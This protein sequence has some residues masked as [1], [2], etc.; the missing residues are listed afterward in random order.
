VTSKKKSQIGAANAEV[1]RCQLTYIENN[2]QYMGYAMLRKKGIPTGSG[3][4]EGVCKSLI[5]IRTKGYGQR[6]HSHGVNAV[7]ALRGLYLSDR[8]HLFWTAM[9]KRREVNIQEAA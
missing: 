9:S 2:K 5:M 3:V 7:L 8:L 1:L 6:W 4:T